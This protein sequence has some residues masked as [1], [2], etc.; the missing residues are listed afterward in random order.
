MSID[1]KDDIQL[2]INGLIK[3]HEIDGRP[4]REFPCQLLQ[5]PF[6]TNDDKV[7]VQLAYPY[8]HVKIRPF[9][10]NIKFHHSKR[11]SDNYDICEAEWNHISIYGKFADK[12]K[13]IIPPKD[14][15]KAYEYYIND[16]LKQKMNQNPNW[17]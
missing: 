3:E 17:I 8:E 5:D 1:G 14:A 6:N 15:K 7:S 9:K 16:Q 11:K 4:L 13:T 12:Y 2:P 10:K